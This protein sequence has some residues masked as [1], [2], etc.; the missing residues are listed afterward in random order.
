MNH[1]VP[2]IARNTG[3]NQETLINN[4][5]LITTNSNLNSKSN[6]NL[7]ISFETE[8]KYFETLKNIEHFNYQH[9]LFDILQAK[10]KY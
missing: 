1:G 4:K 3:G 6:S 5:Y 8:C 9:I 7:K 10:R 2:L